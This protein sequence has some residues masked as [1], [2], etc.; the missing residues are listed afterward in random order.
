MHYAP[1][2]EEVTGELPWNGLRLAL[3]HDPAMAAIQTERRNTRIEALIAQG[4]HWA[5]KL[6]DQDDGV[7]VG[8]ASLTAAPRRALPRRVRGAP[9]EDHQGRSGCRALLLR[10]RR[11]LLAL[12]Q[13]MDGKLL[14]VTNVQDMT[15]AELVSRYKSSPTSSAVSRC[16]NRNSEIGPVY[17]RLPERIRAHAS[18]CFIALILHRIMRARLSGSNTW[19][20]PGALEQ[21]QRIQHHRVRPTVA[22]RLRVSTI[23]TVQSES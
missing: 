6:T 19:L 2:T 13:M 14:L 18:I 20:T 17:H 7:S 11:R 1:A 3:A 8:G 15:P 16:S 12:A 10:D 5:G 9:V 4:E 22:N 21:L 23:N